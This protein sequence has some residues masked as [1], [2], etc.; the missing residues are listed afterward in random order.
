MMHHN[1][2][3]IYLRGFSL[4]NGST[5]I[6]DN[7]DLQLLQGRHYGLV[8]KNGIGKT[9]LLRQIAAGKISQFP[10]NIRTMLVE[11]EATADPNMNAI[12]VLKTHI[13]LR[14]RVCDEV[15][16]RTASA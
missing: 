5:E 12:E 3:D 10:S 13:S 11:Q 8:G 14:I 16:Q 9:T 2:R 6:L 4:S 7:A 15:G 1:S